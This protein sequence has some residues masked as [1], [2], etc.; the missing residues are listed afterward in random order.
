M[1]TVLQ[2]EIIM[3]ISENR[4]P[5]L[6]VF[7]QMMQKTDSL[8]KQD[9][10]LHEEYYSKRSGKAVEQDVFDAV[11]EASKGTEFEGSIQLVSGAIFPD[12]IA[13]KYNGVEV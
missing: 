1:A 2:K 11:C 9:A 7:R 10:R 12:I 5:P 6:E 3:I 13:A 8:L 4:K